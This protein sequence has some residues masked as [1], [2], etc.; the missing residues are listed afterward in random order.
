MGCSD[1]AAKA[2]VLVAAL[3]LA[4]TDVVDLRTALGVDAEPQ[5]VAE[6][7][8]DLMN[9]AKEALAG[10]EDTVVMSTNALPSTKVPARS[11]RLKGPGDPAARKPRVQARDAA[12][13]VD[14]EHQMPG[15]QNGPGG[16]LPQRGRHPFGH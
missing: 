4:A 2:K 5:P 15:P 12:V 14:N 9:R 10:D 6:I 3:R 7:E 16:R 11:P 1:C 13:A 8:A